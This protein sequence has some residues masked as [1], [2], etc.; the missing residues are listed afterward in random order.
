MKRCGIQA[1]YNFGGAGTQA[2]DGQS[3]GLFTS[4]FDRDFEA[5]GR[6]PVGNTV[7]P[8]DQGDAIPG[9]VFVDSQL[10]KGDTR[11][12]SIRVEVINR[13]ASR[14]LIHQDKRGAGDLTR[15]DPRPCGDSLHQAG[16][17]RSQVPL[18]RDDETRFQRPR[19][20]LAKGERLGFLLAV[21]DDG[22]EL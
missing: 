10:G 18:Q 5:I 4:H 11:C 15:I 14:I 17:A 9:E 3:P 16:F 1:A 8:L 19:Q 20:T 22:G 7:G 21:E 12:Q 13:P 6:K 2:A